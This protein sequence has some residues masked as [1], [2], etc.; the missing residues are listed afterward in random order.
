MQNTS[1]FVANNRRRLPPWLKAKAPGNRNYTDIK[2]LVSGKRLN[3]VCESAHC[4]NIGECWG[5]RTATF[6]ILGDVCTRSCGFCAIKTGRPTWLDDEE[7]ERV[8]DAVAHLNLR[9]AVITSVNRDELPDGG[10]KI[11]ALT[12][13]AI[14]IR[15]PETSVEVLIPDFQ[16]NWQ[17]LQTVLDAKPDILNHNIETV[18]RL[19]YKMR[20][21]AKYARSLELLD[22]AARS[23]SGAPTKSGMMLGAGESEKEIQ[24]TIDDLASVD[25][26]IL[27]LGQYLSPS[28]EHVPVERY[29]HPD[30]FEHWRNY[31]INRNFKYVESGP[32]VRSSYHA[33]KQVDEATLRI[34][35]I[36][37]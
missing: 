33:D 22:R 6:M 13:E 25:C 2:R 20:R 30:E 27:T 8:A 32:L 14:N 15:C 23:T 18:P 12:I 4:P 28:P 24:K 34:A 37:K 29:V 31:A 35:P 11:F 21:Q 36:L 9:H 3:T 7:P 1:E 19:Y 26:A 16:G 10:A 17:A 5:N